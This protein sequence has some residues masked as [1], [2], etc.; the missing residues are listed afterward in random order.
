M[1]VRA[2]VQQEIPAQ[3]LWFVMQTTQYDERGSAIFSVCV[4]RVTVDNGNRQAVQQE[5]IMDLL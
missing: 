4:W 3:Q 5:V 1:M 2:N